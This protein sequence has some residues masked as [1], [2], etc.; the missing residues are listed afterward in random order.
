MRRSLISVL[1]AGMTGVAVAAGPAWAE[2]TTQPDNLSCI[3]D[4]P[5]PHLRVLRD[6]ENAFVPEK[7]PVEE[8]YLTPS[9]I[10]MIGPHDGGRKSDRPDRD[11]P[12]NGGNGGGSPGGSSGVN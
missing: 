10:P 5:Q 11:R 8:V 3:S 12:D 4:T 2:T 7:P 1:I 6:C 9:Q